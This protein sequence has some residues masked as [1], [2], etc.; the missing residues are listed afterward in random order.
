MYVETRIAKVNGTQLYYE[1]AGNGPT[2][3][4]IHGFLL[5]HRMWDDQFEIF[6]QK[7]RVVRYDCRG[8]GNSTLPTEEAYSHADDLQALLLHLGITQAHIVGLS[9][10]GEI[11]I[12]FALTYPEMTTTLT[13]SDPL[14]DGYVAAEL[15]QTIAPVVERA[16]IAGGRAAN[17]LL[18]DHVIFAPANEQPTV[19]ARLEEML[20][21]NPG[22]HW[23]NE[24]PLRNMDPPAVTRLQE[25]A[26]PTLVILGERDMADFHTIT[27]ILQQNVIQAR[28]V[29]L[30]GVGHMSN[31]EAPILFNSTVLSFLQQYTD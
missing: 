23:V 26:V 7:Y 15:N 4:L 29:T 9:M 21:E 3:V 14:L 20:T 25:I 2:L 19:R 18:L 10:G 17:A 16:M 27:A 8:F 12:N 13:A 30:P 11:A 1:V 5:D 31:M 28:L 22:W 6:V 24:D